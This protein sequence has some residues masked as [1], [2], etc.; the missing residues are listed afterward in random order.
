MLHHQAKCSNCERLAL[1]AIKSLN[2][3]LSFKRNVDQLIQ[4]SIFS[5]FM[6]NN[7]I[8]DLLDLGKLQNNAFQ[9]NIEQFNLLKVI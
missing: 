4:N 2:K 5:A 9:L 7:L 6:M 8:N 1:L 3:I